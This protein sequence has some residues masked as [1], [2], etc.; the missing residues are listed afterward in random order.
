MTASKG[1]SAK[2]VNE[3]FL[4]CLFKGGEDTSQYV[5]ASGITFKTG[6]HPGR[7]EGHKAEIFALLDEL[8]DDFKESGGGGMSF[9]NA[10]V[11]RHG[12]HWAEHMTIEQL[13]LLGLA[14]GK[15]SYPI[16]DREMWRALPGGVPYFVVHN[17][18]KPVALKTQEAA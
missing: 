4:D 7:L 18:A 11:D 13:L 16:A 9:L 10:C 12:T 17:E 14:T 1:L 2:R 6:L 3:I 5:P 8:P 15:V